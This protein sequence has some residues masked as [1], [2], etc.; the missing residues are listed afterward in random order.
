MSDT[1]RVLDELGKDGQL[2]GGTVI[3]RDG[4][5]M[6]EVVGSDGRVT[7]DGK[8]FLERRKKGGEDPKKDTRKNGNEDDLQK[9]VSSTRPDVPTKS[10]PA[11]TTRSP[12]SEV[13]KIEPVDGPSAEERQKKAADNA[14]QRDLFADLDGLEKE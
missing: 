7:A 4:F 9:A 3:A 1:K 6:V 12:K 11:R 13:Q 8:D 5:T 14:G 2:V 10:G